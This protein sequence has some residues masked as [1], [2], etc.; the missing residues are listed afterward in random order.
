M[1]KEKLK[2]KLDVSAQGCWLSISRRNR[3]RNLEP[4]EMFMFRT[5]KKVGIRPCTTKRAGFHVAP[6]HLPLQSTKKM[7]N[8][9]PKSALQRRAE[10]GIFIAH[11]LSPR[12]CVLRHINCGEVKI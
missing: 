8:L 1:E 3:F 5:Q 10:Y 7:G 6:A 4:G 12:F 9:Q 2:F 11:K